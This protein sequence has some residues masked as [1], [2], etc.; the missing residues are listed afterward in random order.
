LEYLFRRISESVLAPNVISSLQ[1]HECHEMVYN[2]SYEHKRHALQ[3]VIEHTYKSINC[4]VIMRISAS[5]IV[6]SDLEPFDNIVN[7]VRGLSI[8]SKKQDQLLCL[9]R[10][11]HSIFSNR[12]A[13]N[14]LYT[15]IF[16]V[17]KD[18]PF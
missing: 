11:F 16:D 13:C 2:T 9:L 4:E 15:F 6:S 3:S 14:S 12:P 10:E 1:I 17:I 18:K 8:S 7:R 5:S